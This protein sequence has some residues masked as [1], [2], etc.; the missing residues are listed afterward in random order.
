MQESFFRTKHLKY[1][2]ITLHNDIIEMRSWSGF[3]YEFQ[4]DKSRY[5]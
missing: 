5:E 2:G 1:S 3:I 4:A